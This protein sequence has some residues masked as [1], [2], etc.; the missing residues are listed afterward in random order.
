MIVHLLFLWI[1][2][3]RQAFNIHFLTLQ[4]IYLSCNGRHWANQGS[5]KRLAQPLIR[6]MTDVTKRRFFSLIF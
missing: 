4:K 6:T 3:P 5:P 2:L 1:Y